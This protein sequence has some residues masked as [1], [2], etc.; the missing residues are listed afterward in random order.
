MPRLELWHK[1]ISF[2]RKQILLGEVLRKERKR[3]EGRAGRRKGGRKGERKR[4]GSGYVTSELRSPEQ[5]S[6]A[7]TESGQY[8]AKKTMRDSEKKKIVTNS[9]KGLKENANNRPWI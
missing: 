9:V 6:N 4:K 1:F 5:H 2:P 3:Q 8:T 7:A